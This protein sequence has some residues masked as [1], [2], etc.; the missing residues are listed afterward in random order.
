MPSQSFHK[1][2]LLK[3]VGR[4]LRLTYTILALLLVLSIGLIFTPE[5]YQQF[6]QLRQNQN[7]IP[8]DDDFADVWQPPAETELPAGEAGDLIRY[9]RDLIAN[10]SVYLGPKGNVMQSS[11]GMNCQ[12]CHLDA[13]T[14]PFGNNFSAVA[15]TYPKF[16]ARS[17]TEESIGKR[18][19]DCF[20][21]SLNGQAL[22][23]DSKEMLAI[24]AY[25]NWLGKD[26]AKGETPK[27]AGLIELA[28]LDRAA[29]PVKGKEKYIEAC[30]ICHGEQG[31]GMINP[32]STGWTNPPLWGKESYTT[33][34]GLYRLSR[35]AGYIKANMPF[36]ATYMKP[37]LTDEEAWDLA[38]YVNSLPHPGK[39][40]SHD[41][42]DISK[43]P[44]DHP[45]GPFDDGFSDLQHKF[46]PF[47]PIVDKRK[48]INKAWVSNK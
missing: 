4:L 23:D 32:D 29:D 13:G 33:A 37:E 19:N 38:A 3:F 2:Q 7:S 31:E 42:P 14:K 8:A 28:F 1:D 48:E 41:W 26:V 17:G 21:R 16:R 11:N 18:V 34:A 20:E 24:V 40:I 43:K 22:A 30:V 47:K 44:V 9:G 36:G 35:F 10:T 25:I 27:G 12:N 6:M 46:G 5:I 45:F 39:D 15:A